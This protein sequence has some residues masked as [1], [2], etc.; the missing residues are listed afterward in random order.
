[1]KIKMRYG[2]SV[3]FDKEGINEIVKFLLRVFPKEKEK[4]L[5]F[6]N[7]CRYQEYATEIVARNLQPWLERLPREIRVEYHDIGVSIY[8]LVTVNVPT[9]KSVKLFGPHPEPLEVNDE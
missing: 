4:I 7:F 9:P 2:L 5:T 6:R 1:V 8:Q 3:D